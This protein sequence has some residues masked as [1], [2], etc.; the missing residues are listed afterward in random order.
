M[1]RFSALMLELTH[2]FGLASF[3]AMNSVGVS[4]TISS[5]VQYGSDDNT[6]SFMPHTISLTLGARYIPLDSCTIVHK[7]V[8]RVSFD[9]AEA[10]IFASIIQPSTSSTNLNIYISSRASGR[11][12]SRRQSWKNIGPSTSGTIAN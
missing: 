1:P 5:I 6:S 7:E 9:R 2:L 3:N 11:K 4:A 8:H 10:A 12:P